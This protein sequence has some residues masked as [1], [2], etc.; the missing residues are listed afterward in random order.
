MLTSSAVPSPWRAQST[1]G[2]WCVSPEFPEG[3]YAFFVAIDSSFLPA[4]PDFIARQY[5]GVEQD[6]SNV[7]FYALKSPQVTTYAV[8][9][10]SAMRIDSLEND[11]EIVTLRWDSADLNRWTI[12]P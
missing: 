8:G 7:G 1:H 2:R 6:G 3:T 4:Q 12:M 11:G 9:A 10:D 5:H